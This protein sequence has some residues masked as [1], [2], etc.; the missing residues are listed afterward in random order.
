MVDRSVSHLG[1]GVEEIQALDE[2]VNPGGQGLAGLIGVFLLGRRD[3]H[4]NELLLGAMGGERGQNLAAGPPPPTLQSLP[5]VTA[6]SG[7]L[8]LVAGPREAW[9]CSQLSLELA[10]GWSWPW[11]HQLPLPW[12]AS[13][14]EG[15]GV[16]GS[17]GQGAV[18]WLSWYPQD[19]NLGF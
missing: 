6:H 16:E 19:S 11:P 4:R 2:I 3:G 13:W 9:P 1:P 5:H 7:L 8:P 17:M 18:S 15:E 14:G 12:C 10:R